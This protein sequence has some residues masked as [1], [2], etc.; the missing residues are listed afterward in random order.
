M[1]IL[2]IEDQ[3]DIRDT[4]RDML[5]LHGHEVLLA[6][7]GVEGVA[8]ASLVPDFILCD[9]AMPRLDGFG[10]LQAVRKVPATAEVPFVFLT[11]KAERTDLREG[12]SLGADDYITKP[13]TEREVLDTIA[14]RTRR[15]RGVREK[16]ASLQ[17]EKQRESSAHWSHELL[18]PL[19]AI[20]GCLSILD[21]EADSISPQDLREVLATLRA[22]AEQQER[23]AWKLI[24]Y[25]EL[26]QV[27]A[28]SVSLQARSCRVDPLA[29]KAAETV[30]K[31][32]SRAQDLV[33][34][35]EPAELRSNPDFLAAAVGE[36]V[37]NACRFSDEGS[38]IVL[39]GYIRAGEYVIQVDDAGPGL[40][41]EQCAVTAAFVQFRHR[42]REVRGL[43]LGL[44]IVRSVAAIAGGQLRLGSKPVGSGLR[45]ELVMPLTH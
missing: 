22:G 39:H 45:A 10:V 16:I 9:I 18:T 36:L 42:S 13:F 27:K 41:P 21:Q 28:G 7:D 30:A 32:E 23:L 40:S 29:S 11:A 14:A 15:G 6:S 20:L 2:V 17:A 33:C 19:N 12:M 44:S 34:S 3:E 43:G 5:E 4:L 25:F 8:M 37:E 38:P 1:K 35:I 26:E 31:A 24:R